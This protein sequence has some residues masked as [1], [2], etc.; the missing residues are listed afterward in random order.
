[1]PL[2]ARPLLAKTGKYIRTVVGLG[3]PELHSEFE[4]LAAKW[5]GK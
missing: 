3:L 2:I 1:M 5:T 4:M